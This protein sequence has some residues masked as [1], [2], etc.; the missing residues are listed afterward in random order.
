MKVFLDTNVLVS[1][2]TARGLC[3]ELLESIFDEHDLLTCEPV[4]QE[5]KRI[6]TGKFHLPLPLVRDYLNLLR[7][8][9]QVVTTQGKV[10]IKINDPDDILILSF[11]IPAR[12]D[13]FVT[14]DQELLKLGNIGDVPI[15]SPR[16]FW[17]TLAGIES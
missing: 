10:N 2:L 15:L 3:S 7:T 5:I 17:L 8:E 6:L 1:G 12:P 4:L 13:V 9:G 14:G 11:A 16:K